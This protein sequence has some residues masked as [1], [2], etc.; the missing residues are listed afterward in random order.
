[1]FSGPLSK[2]DRVAV[3]LEDLAFA[4]PPRW[5]N[6]EWASIF[7]SQAAIYTFD[8]SGWQTE[9]APVQH[10]ATVHFNNDITFTGWTQNGREVLTHWQ[11]GPAY[12]VTEMNMGSSVDTPPSPVFIFL[13]LLDG[14]GALVGGSDRFD[15]DA[16]SLQPGDKF[17]Q[18]HAF[19]PELPAGPYGI[20]I[21]LYN[22]ISG[23]RYITG[24]GRDTVILGE[25]EITQ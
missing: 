12:A 8:V 5:V 6:T 11:V 1:V 23:Q 2:W 9:G 21:G 13:H 22:P 20:E 15:V 14:T 18:R 16:F 19:A 7:T 3:E 10:P 24:D 17:V 4:S 25:I